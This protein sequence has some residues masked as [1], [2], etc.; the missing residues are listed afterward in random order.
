MFPF[1]DVIMCLKFQVRDECQWRFLPYVWGKNT[2]ME[3]FI[4]VT[5][6]D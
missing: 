6:S 1:D 5:S 2:D 4:A 3:Y